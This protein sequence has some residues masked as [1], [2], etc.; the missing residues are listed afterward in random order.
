MD[1]TLN[2][3]DLARGQ[4]LLSRL[5]DRYFAILKSAR[6]EEGVGNAIACTFEVPGAGKRT[7]SA[8]SSIEAIRLALIELASMLANPFFSDPAHPMNANVSSTG[9]AALASNTTI[10]RFHSKTRQLTVGV[11]MPTSLKEHLNTLADSQGTSFAEI[12]RRFAVFGFEDFIDRSLFV[13]SKSLFD[14]LGREL[15]KW[16]NSDH[17]QVMLRLQPGHAVRIR[18]TAKEYGK[19]VSE[20]GA[21]CLAHG[22]VLQEQ[23]AS[24][25]QKLA[26][27]KGPAIRPLL[28]QLGLGS[29]AASL[30]SGVFVGNIRAPKALLKKLSNFFEAQ[31]TVLA[32]LFERSF[33]NRMVPAFKS[34]N[35]KPEVSKVPTQWDIAVRSLDLPPDQTKALLDL[36]A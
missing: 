22:F 2:L 20:F 13:S 7:A 15:T 14:T 11:T 12:A 10:E 24:L 25:E 29:Y 27:C 33:E 5:P 30:L 19:S 1:S 26:S 28:T 8:P 16:Q 34:E 9:G 32:T 4:A 31:E 35:G 23:L 36:G 18:S 21:L 6:L 17:E 3:V